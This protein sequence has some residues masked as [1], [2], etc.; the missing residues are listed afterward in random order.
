M[1]RQPVTVTALRLETF[2]CNFINDCSNAIQ[3]KRG[4]I[5]CYHTIHGRTTN[6]YINSEHR[7]DNL[8]EVGIQEH[9]AKSRKLK[10]HKIFCDYF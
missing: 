4:Q 3:K 1:A 6:K 8:D 10:C 7:K 9:E 2:V 5:D